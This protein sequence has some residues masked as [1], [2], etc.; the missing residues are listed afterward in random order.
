[1]ADMDLRY[2]DWNTAYGVPHG[3]PYSEDEARKRFLEGGPVTILKG[4]VAAPDFLLQIKL[5][6]KLVVATWLDGLQRPEVKYLWGQPVEDEGTHQRR[7]LL[8][9]VVLNEYDHAE[10][11]PGARPTRGEVTFFQSNGDFRSQKVD[12]ASGDQWVMTGSKPEQLQWELV[13]EFGTWGPFCDYA[14]E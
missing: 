4:E 8:H 10:R 9:Q 1:M 11:P 6:G 7:L 12:F 5:G 14:R 13:P 2:H 3:D